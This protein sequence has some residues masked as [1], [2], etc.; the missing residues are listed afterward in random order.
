MLFHKVAIVGAGLIGGSLG[1]ALRQRKLAGRVVGIGYRAVSLVQAQQR[2]CIDDFTLEMQE[3]VCDADLVVIGTPVSL[4]AEK[5][6]EMAPHLAP[7]CIVTDVASTKK[8]IV[9]QLDGMFGETA[10]FVGSHPMAGSEKRGSEHSDPSMFDGALCILTRTG[11]TD[12]AAAARVAEMWHGVG[13]RTLSMPPEQH[14]HYVALASHVPH[15]VAACLVGIQ[16][17]TSLQC[18]GSGFKD[19]TRIAAS[20]PELWRDIMLGNA[21]EVAGGIDMLIRELTDLRALIETGDEAALLDKLA[22]A[23]RKR[24][25][26]Y[27]D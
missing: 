16:D 6:R 15:A 27:P 12:P 5:A 13:M 9:E 2:G 18:A 4:V 19:A 22:E 11:H 14:D 26:R 3:G 8:Q 20:D 1:A 7:G 25:S 17:A 24:S 23:N 21:A 10:R